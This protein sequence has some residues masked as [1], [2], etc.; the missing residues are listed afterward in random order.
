[1]KQQK[2]DEAEKLG[3]KAII[4][5]SAYPYG[6]SQTW[7]PT[8]LYKVGAKLESIGV[9]TDVVDLN[10]EEIPSN[11]TRYDYIGIGV[12]GAPYVPGTIQL[13]NEVREKTGKIPLLGGPGVEYLSNEEFRQLYGDSVQI[14][15]DA[16]L[17]A[18]V[19]RQLPLVYKASI[20]D[21]IRNLPPLLA[22]KY[23]KAEFSFFVSQGCKYACDFCAAVR[24]RD[25]NKVSE[26][27]SSVMQEDL[28]AIVERAN[29][30]GVRNL[31]MYITSLDLFQNPTQ[32]KGALEIFAQAQ[33]RYGIKFSLRGLS[34]VDS[35]LNAMEKEPELYDVIPKSGLEV[36][37]FGVDGTTEEV[38]K[39]Q[40]KGNKSLSKVDEAFTTCKKLNITPEAL[41][42]MGF[43]D[44]K[45][46]PVD[47][48]TS[49]S[50]NVDYSI[51]CA[52]QYGVVSRPHVAKDMVPGNNGWRN[53]IWAKQRQRLLDNPLLFKNLDFVTLASE[54]THPNEEFRNYVNDAYL[55]IVGK[56]SPRGLCVTNPL[57]PYTGNPQQDK[58]ADAFN[59]LVPTDK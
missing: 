8:D 25:G 3:K 42:V 54:I 13:A 58:V 55:Q 48:K 2:I 47:T 29:E 15:N 32:F 11:L 5:R 51:R 39:S 12:I 53:P 10:L 52:D 56:L 20:A 17:S 49:L 50:K 45:G 40:H 31:T 4:L 6:K 59:L 44:A 16:D 26:Q 1:M 37:G 22:D 28:D 41:M 23:L 57:M 19:G 21:R 38:W 27:F 46:K 18:I 9:Q 24:T 36:V 35:F 33:Q 34:R 14:R 30:F 7:L 43:H